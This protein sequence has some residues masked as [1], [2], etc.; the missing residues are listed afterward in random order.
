MFEFG[1]PDQLQLAL[2]DLFQKQ[3]MAK[4]YAAYG[5]DARPTF[6]L[7]ELQGQ[8]IAALDMSGGLRVGQLLE[9]DNVLPEHTQRPIRRRLNS[10]R[11]HSLVSNP[12]LGRSL[13]DLDSHWWGQQIA[14]ATDALQHLHAAANRWCRCSKPWR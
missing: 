1:Q 4:Y 3:G 11:G 6:D 5:D 9:S 13:R 14:Q 8:K 2:T 12:H 10:A 7:I